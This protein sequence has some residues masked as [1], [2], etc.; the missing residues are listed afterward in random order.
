[1]ASHVIVMTIWQ[2]DMHF[3]AVL[4]PALPGDKASGRGWG[5]GGS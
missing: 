3:E 5:V 4:G 2:H 1:M